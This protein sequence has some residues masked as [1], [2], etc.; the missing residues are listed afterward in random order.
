MSNLYVT[1]DVVG[2][3]SGGG[4][5]TFN[6][7]EALK[8]L[9]PCKVWDRNKL[10]CRM[11]EPLVDDP[12]WWDNHG[13]WLSV[14]PDLE[15]KLAHFYAGTFDKTVARLRS[16]GVKVTYT[17]AAHD[18]EA[19]RREHEKLGV[20]FNYPHLTDPA[21]WGRY[22]A[23]YK[24]ADVLIVP[25]KHSADVMRSYGCTNRIEII[26]HGIDL[27]TSEKVRPIRTDKFVAGYLGACGAPDKGLRYLLEAWSKLN[28]TDAEL[29]LA[30]PDS[31]S[32]WVR[33]LIDR[34]GEVSSHSVAGRIRTLGWV[35]DISEFYNQI[36]LYVQ[37]SVTEGFGIEVL[38]AASYCRPVICSIGAGAADCVPLGPD[39]T[40]FKVHAGDSEDLA[41]AINWC[42]KSGYLG[43]VGFM[44]RAEAEKFTWAKIRQRYVELWRSLLK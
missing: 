22:L 44:N 27:P 2:K 20:P 8:S 13:D 32:E 18:K 12:F 11:P 7:S 6:E 40:Q 9:G 35:N 31:Q 28:Y 33:R 41:S 34:F 16:Q 37:P 15:M 5:V 17:A 1:A 14:V 29:I 25:S 36:S 39:F 43:E 26:P 10:Q 42:R 38:E 21:L 23:G 30:G 3:E 19:S 4:K 24:A